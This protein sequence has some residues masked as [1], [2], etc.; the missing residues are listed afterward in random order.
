[1][2]RAIGEVLPLAVGVAISPLAVI[3]VIVMLMSERGT[4]NSMSF[5]AGWLVGVVTVTTATLALAEGADAATDAGARDGIS[6]IRLL[7]GALFVALAVRTW[8][9]RPPEGAPPEEPG[10][11]AAI[12][13]F[14]AAKSF[15]AGAAIATLLAPK[16]IALEIAGGSAVA[17]HGLSVTADM[18]VIAFFALATAV[19][20]LVPVVASTVAG[21][22]AA[23]PLATTRRWLVANNTAIM[24]VLFVVLAAVNIGR[25]LRLAG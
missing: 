16:N 22:R 5:I 19:P 8:R 2:L 11:I 3:I 20:L 25:G 1:M 9:K 21:E 10:Y 23:A 24:L 13:S 4:A 17:E 7:I 18:V 15:G 12:E 6:V 14:N